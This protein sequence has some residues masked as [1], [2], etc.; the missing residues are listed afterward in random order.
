M[1]M[2]MVDEVSK[3]NTKVVVIGLKKP[4]HLKQATISFM[5]TPHHTTPH[6]NTPHRTTPHYTTPH[7]TTPHHTTLHHTTPHHTTET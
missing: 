3:G 5:A 1:T 7:H 6:H 4:P 2:M